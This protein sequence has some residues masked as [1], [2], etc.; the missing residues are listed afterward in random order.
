MA[1][2]L[3][4]SLARLGTNSV[5]L[6]VPGLANPADIPLRLCFIPNGE[7]FK[8]DPDDLESDHWSLVTF[9]YDAVWRAML[10]P[11]PALRLGGMV[12]DQNQ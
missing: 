2:S 4:I 10:V 5:C 8:L 9:L 7:A 12:Q 11:S 6:H 1:N 3:H